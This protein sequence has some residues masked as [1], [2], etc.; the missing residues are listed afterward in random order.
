LPYNEGVPR[1]PKPL[2][3]PHLADPSKRFDTILTALLAVPKSEA[4]EVLTK[5]EAEKRKVDAKLAEV[6]REL[7]KRK[8]TRRK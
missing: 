7:A 2:P 4:R 5:L 1:K 3:L 8:G 6:R